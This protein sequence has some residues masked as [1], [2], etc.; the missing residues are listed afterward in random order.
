MFFLQILKCIRPRLFLIFSTQSMDIY[1]LVNKPDA[2]QEFH[3]K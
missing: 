3:L 1:G 2:T